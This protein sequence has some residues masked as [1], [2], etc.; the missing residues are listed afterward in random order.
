MRSRLLACWLAALSTFLSAA[1]EPSCS[2]P[3][4]L[5]MPLASRKATF[6]A[7][8]A[9]GV[10][11]IVVPDTD[12]WEV[13]A[14]GA[15]DPHHKDNLLYPAGNWHGAFPCQVQPSLAPD[16]FPSPRVIPIRG[17][18]ASL[19]LRLLSPQVQGTSASAHF[20]GGSLEVVWVGG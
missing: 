6:K 14:F 13:Q 19:C 18:N 12:G 8:A 11:I 3:L 4:L 15:A 1:P 17:V 10:S 5:K 20:T 7:R 16:I 9:S 2:G